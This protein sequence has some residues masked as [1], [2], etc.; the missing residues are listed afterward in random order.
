MSKNY[1]QIVRRPLIL[2][3]VK[4][5]IKEL[6][7]EISLEDAIKEAILYGEKFDTLPTWLF[8]NGK[9]YDFMHDGVIETDG[10]RCVGKVHNQYYNGRNDRISV[11]KI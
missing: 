6:P 8:H 7:D 9:T 1:V 2:N 4:E 10:N 5:F 3:Q 11:A